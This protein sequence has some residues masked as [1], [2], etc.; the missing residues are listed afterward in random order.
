[1]DAL[2]EGDLL[3]PAVG[4]GRGL[5]GEDGSRRVLGLQVLLPARG[6]AL[7]QLLAGQRPCLDDL[8]HGLPAVLPSG[9]LQHPHVAPM[10][11]DVELALPDLPGQQHVQ[12][13]LVPVV[14]PPDPQRHPLQLGK[15]EQRDASEVLVVMWPQRVVTT[16]AQLRLARR[17]EGWG[18][19]QR[20]F[21]AH[22]LVP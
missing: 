4:A 21:G 2:L 3:T 17:D 14:H 16:H 8:A 1:M 11:E 20:C 13:E 22:R 10:N 19:S 5:A 6:K 9:R 15:S 12:A 18:V 7:A